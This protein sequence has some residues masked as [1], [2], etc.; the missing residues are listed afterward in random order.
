M[1]DVSSERPLM[2]PS[3]G[4]KVDIS[5]LGSF[6]L[7]AEARAEIRAVERRARR[8]IETSHLFHFGGSK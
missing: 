4:A 5:D 1:T 7:S 2:R 8:V 6:Q 3:A